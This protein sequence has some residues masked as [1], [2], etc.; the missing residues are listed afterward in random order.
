MS[1]KELYAEN[2]Y[3]KECKAQIV[4]V[5]GNLII[6]DQTIFYPGGGGQP[7]DQGTIKQGDE[8]YEVVNVKKIDGEIVHELDRPLQ[9][10]EQAVI[11]HIN[12]SWRFQN[13]R[14]HTLLHVISGY[15][16]QHYGA[17]ATSSQ[18]EKDYARLELAFSPEVIEE[19]QFEELE[20]SICRITSEHHDVQI[21]TISRKEA[22][23]KVGS[24]KTIINLLPASLNE[25]R[26]V[27]IDDI[28]EQAC[29]G[30]HVS[31]TTEIGDFSIIKIQNKGA[32]KR[33]LKIQLN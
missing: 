16:F 28:D 21:K 18:I 26:L 17:L 15:L 14:Y 10:L 31:K 5:N 2:S 25:V 23:Q 12:W 20:Q 22:E 29:G 6:F 3:I 1:T 24:I 33:R 13:M 30:T 19:I 11:M 32:T 7:C 27:Q 9:H 8:I 4:S